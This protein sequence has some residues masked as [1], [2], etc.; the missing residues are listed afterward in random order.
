MAEA[1]EEALN[2]LSTSASRWHTL[3]AS[4]REWRDTALASEAW[5]AQLERRRAEGQSFSVISSQSTLPRPD[6]T[7]EQW[8]LWI[9]GSWT[10]AIFVAGHSDVDVVFD[11]ST[12]W[13]NGHDISRTNGGALN[14]GHGEGPGTQLVS[15]VEYPALIEIRTG[16]VGSRIGR[17]TLDVKATTRRG[18]PRRRGRGLH[19]LVIGD[20]DE[21]HLS[22]D[23]ERGVILCAESWFTGQPYRI[24]KMDKVAFD[25]PLGPETFVIAPL[26]GLHWV[27]LAHDGRRAGGP[28]GPAP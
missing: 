20:A 2:L 24:L 5:H 1:A 27:D 18:L 13:S 9:A 4:G 25:E 6:Q 11:G 3:W 14:H 23:R 15:T 12:W 10:R 28:L 16:T 19:G 21:I 8:Q 26:P 7:D 22:I 17:E